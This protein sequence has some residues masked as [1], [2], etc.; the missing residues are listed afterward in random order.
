[1][2]LQR[3]LEM[4]GMIEGTHYRQQVSVSGEGARA[5]PDF[6]IQ[7]PGS[8]EIVV[9][10]KT[11]VEPYWD[12]LEKADSE[13]ARDAALQ[14]FRRHMR[15]HLKALSGK[16]YW[17]HFDAPEF[18]VMFLPTEGLYTMAVSG[19]PALIED[20]ARA[21]VILASPTTLMGLLRVVM[22][23]WQ[24]QKMAEEAKTVSAL[25]ADLYNRLCAFGDHMQ[26]VGTGLGTAIGAYNKAV[27]SLENSVLR[28][29]RKLR[30]LH[31]QTG[32]KE[33]AEMGEIAE[34][35][36]TLEI[37]HQEKDGGGAEA[38]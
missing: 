16:E 9:D 27:G 15:D 19:D 34:T 36:R 12:A 10:V 13:A 21:N 28:P 6:I 11:P 35:A 25:A 2:Q 37:A 24:Q 7:M 38:A 29:A 8:M 32:G 4:I 30:E 14:S 22:H 18:V 5:R 17:R 20:A 26:R 23:G 3:A 31:V 1:M 33:L